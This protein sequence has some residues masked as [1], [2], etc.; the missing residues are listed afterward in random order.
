MATHNEIGKWGEGI[1]AKWLIERGYQILERNW[2]LGR[3]EIDLI[4]AKGEWLHF[5]EVKTRSSRQWGDPEI[6]VTPQKFSRW[7]NAAQG[8]L[9]QQRHYRW[10]QF[11]I[12]AI[13][14][15]NAGKFQ[16]ELFEDV[17]F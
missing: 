16:L 10:I 8:Y 11:D 2:K 13:T 1:A 15:E 3:L 5:I 17:Y 14:L 12:I 6:S 4:A 7:R 9:W